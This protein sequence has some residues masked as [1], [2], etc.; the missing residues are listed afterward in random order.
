MTGN[1]L[2][3]PTTGGSAQHFPDWAIVDEEPKRLPGG[4][5][6]R[7]EVTDDAAVGDEPMGP[8]GSVQDLVL[9]HDALLAFLH[10][11]QARL[12]QSWCWLLRA[13]QDVLV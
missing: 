9:T 10:L 7:L 1:A 4:E 5:I 12:S 13:L 11:I 3:T 8:V 2:H 6:G